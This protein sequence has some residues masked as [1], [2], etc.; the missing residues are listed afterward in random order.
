MV[1]IPHIQFKLSCP[2]N[3][4][5]PVA[6][7]PARNARPHLM[8]ARLLFA[9]QRQVLRQQ[10]SRANQRHV[11]FKNIN[12]LWQLVY[13]RRTYKFTNFCQS[14]LIGQQISIGVAL[15]G[16]GLELDDLKYLS[17]LAWSFLHEERSSTFVSKVQPDRNNQKYR[18]NHQQRAQSN[19]EIYYSFKEML[20]HRL[21]IF[22]NM[23][24]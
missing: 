24:Y 20:I 1:Y 15:V 8:P 14:S 5:S 3:C 16:H 2:I 21:F 9:V 6:L 18:P 22:F 17:I 11:T 7:C 13:R 19:N 4:V 10:R 12:Q 23:T